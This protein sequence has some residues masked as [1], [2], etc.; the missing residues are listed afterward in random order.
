ME[1]T[2]ITLVSTQG[3]KEQQTLIGKQG[4]N[5]QQGMRDLHE[6]RRL[7]IG[8]NCLQMPYPNCWTEAPLRQKQNIKQTPP[9]RRNHLGK[10]TEEGEQRP[11]WWPWRGSILS[12][13]VLTVVE[14]EKAA[15]SFSKM[16]LMLGR[17]GRASCFCF[18]THQGM[19]TVC[20]RQ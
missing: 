12:A 14:I 10:S 18:T 3:G 9:Q 11:H 8:G 1:F 5:E 15:M 19:G 16:R 13:E 6:G 20:L 4:D 2:A 7:P 17:T